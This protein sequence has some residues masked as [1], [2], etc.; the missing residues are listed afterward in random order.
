L[1]MPL[2]L[3]R[4]AATL[5]SS[6]ENPSQMPDGGVTAWLR[7]HWLA[8]S[9]LVS[10]V[11]LG[12][13][14]IVLGSSLDGSNPHKIHL[15]A[16]KAL[17]TLA[18]GFLLGGVLKLV[19]DNHADAKKRREETEKADRE[20]RAEASK[21]YDALIADMHDNHDRLET[22]RLLIAAHRSAKT[23]GERMRDVVAAHVVLLKSARMKGMGVLKPDPADAECL[24]WMLAYLVALQR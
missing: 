8:S 6:R 13:V 17:A 22:A 11:A 10:A 12:G 9:L 7:R 23:Y 16:A 19:T 5:M 2:G 24:A 21:R 3:G 15:E 1:T 14:A 18:T 4:I 20:L